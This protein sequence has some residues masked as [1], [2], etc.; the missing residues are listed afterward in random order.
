MTHMT[1]IM[2]HLPA[3]RHGQKAQSDAALR[4]TMTH[5]DAHLQEN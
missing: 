3:V 2:T 5:H 4:A 1:H